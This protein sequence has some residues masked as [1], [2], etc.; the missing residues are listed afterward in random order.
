MQHYAAIVLDYFPQQEYT[1]T[2]KIIKETDPR[3]R[4][5]VFSEDSK[6]QS[7]NFCIRQMHIWLSSRD[8][9]LDW[10]PVQVDTPCHM[11]PTKGRC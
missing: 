8:R 9:I 2:V 4:Y 3:N 11:E 6:P 7:F 5:I 10:Y 1:T